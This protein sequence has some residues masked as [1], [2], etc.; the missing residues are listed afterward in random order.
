MH[1]WSASFTSPASR[2]AGE[3]TRSNVCE[4]P[5]TFAASGL[6]IKSCIADV[7]R[8]TLHCSDHECTA[9]EKFCPRAV[10]SGWVAAWH[11]VIIAR[12]V[13]TS[14]GVG[15]SCFWM[16]LKACWNTVANSSWSSVV[17]PSRKVFQV[18]MFA[19]KPAASAF[20][21]GSSAE[22]PSVNFWK[23]SRTAISVPKWSR[24]LCALE[25]HR[26]FGFIVIAMMV[27]PIFSNA[28]PT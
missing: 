5:S 13:S 2:N 12:H 18:S 14:S 27:L 4:T 6:S 17:A 23:P 7:K 16:L 20:R 21:S 22:S 9:S 10:K 1:F 24:K 3:V 8:T 15:R 28:L 19:S 11:A 25:A 26:E